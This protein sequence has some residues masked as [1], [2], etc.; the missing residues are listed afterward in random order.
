MNISKKSWHYRLI[1]HVSDYYAPSSLCA[2]VRKLLGCICLVIVT[3]LVASVLVTTAVTAPLLWF[4]IISPSPQSLLYTTAVIGS[5]AW[6]GGILTGIGIGIHELRVRKLLRQWDAPP[7][8]PSLL[9][10][11]IQAKKQKICP[12]ITFTEN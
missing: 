5:G 7:K 11:W 2:Y 9:S 3:V 1:T 6:T 8:Q 10:S 12:L 4:G